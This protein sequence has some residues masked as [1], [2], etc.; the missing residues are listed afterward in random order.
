MRS[1]GRVTHEQEGRSARCAADTEKKMD[2][3]NGVVMAKTMQK[4][5]TVNRIAFFICLSLMSGQA[6]SVEFNTDMLDANDKS[7]ID[8]SAFSRAGYILPGNYQL[9]LRLNGEGLGTGERDVPFYIRTGTGVEDPLPEACLSPVLLQQMGLT[10]DGLKKTGTWRNGECADFSGLPGATLTPEL[11]TGKLNISIPQMWLEYTDATWLPP[12]RWDH[13]IPGLLLDYSINGMTSKSDSS[14]RRDYLSSSGTAGLNAGAWRLRADYQASYSRAGGRFASETH[15]LNISRLYA[16]RPL[17]S[18]QSR[19]TIGENYVNSTLFDSWR[20]AGA[21]VESDENMLPPKLR[22]YAPEIIGVAKT[23]ARVTVTQQGRV[24]Y[25]STVP[26]GPFRIQEM[27]SA[28]RGQL[29]VKVT[30]QNGEEHT[31]SVSTASVPYLTRPGR[32]R[33]QVLVGRPTTWES[34]MEGGMFTAADL[35]WGISNAWSAYGGTILS[36][37]YQSV[38]LGVGRDLFALGTIAFDVTQSFSRLAGKGPS[39]AD[40]MSG[41]SLR[42]SYSKRFDDLNTDV[43]F[44]GYRFT[45]RDYLTMQQHLDARYRGSLSDR[46]RERYQVMLSKHFDDLAIPLSLN[47]NYET[48]TYWDRGSTDNYGISAGTWFD[49]PQLGLRGVSLNL[50]ANRSQYYGKNDDAINLMLSLPLGGDSLSLSG[51]YSGKRYNESVG[52]YGRVD[53]LNSYNLNASTSHGGNYDSAQSFSGMFSSNGGMADVSVNVGM[54]NDSY[55]SA[56]FSL[57]GGLTAT[58]EGVAL[59]AGGYGGGTRLMVDTDGVGG[60]PVDGGRTVT[61]P[62]GVGVVTGMGNYYRNTTRV[63]LD[64]LPDDVE[65]TLGVTESALTEGAIGYRKF[66]V[67]KGSRLFAVLR[68]PDGT[69]P[70]FGASVRNMKGR[71]L[72]IVSDEGLAWLSGISPTDRLEVS[73]GGSVQCRVQIPLK[74]EPDSQMLLPCETGTPV[75]AQEAEDA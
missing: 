68:L 34:R 57:S 9:Q 3:R 37:E 71:E 39:G 32:V 46:P 21:V 41:K 48:Q 47:L 67:L 11:S 69:W 30:E 50:T 14:A 54:Q 64:R 22:G 19:L 51:G 61:N 40:D 36:K 28:T 8:F 13:G 23:N 75:P 63:D 49:V 20:Y 38:A 6:V 66:E 53:N 26:A 59:H 5:F 16:Y 4:H 42:V 2:N 55:T 27:T 62:W 58:T 15:D 29:D 12:S 18:L 70:P 35:S 7:N 73:W 74:I 56:G 33:Y 60:V 25:E 31:F 24:V 17:T 43:T 72:G 52:Y 45:E 1:P 10:E 65:A 44:A